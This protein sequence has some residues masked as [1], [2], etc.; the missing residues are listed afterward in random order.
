[1][2]EKNRWTDAQASAGAP[3]AGLGEMSGSIGSALLPN[4]FD[5]RL[6]SRQAGVLVAGLLMNPQAESA[7]N[8]E[9]RVV[10][11]KG[12]TW[13]K[14]GDAWSLRDDFGKKIDKYDG[15]VVGVEKNENGVVVVQLKDGRTVHE[16]P[17]GSVFTYSKN[18]ELKRIDS[19]DGTFRE[20]DWDGKELVGFRSAKGAW[21]RIK[22]GNEYKDKWQQ[23]NVVN[24]QSWDGKIQVDLTNGEVSIGPADGAKGDTTVYKTDGKQVTVHADGSKEIVYPN[25]ESFKYDA[26]GN[27]TEGNYID[28]TKRIFGW[29]KNPNATGDNDRF[30]LTSLT[31]N[32]KEGGSYHH[33]LGSDGK[34]TVST[35]ENNV[36]GKAVPEDLIINVD[37]KEGVYS[38][39]DTK[40][41]I[42]TRRIPGGIEEDLDKN[43]ALLETRTRLLNGRDVIEYA[44]TKTRVEKLNGQI[45]AVS[46]EGQSVEAVRD[47]KNRIVELIDRANNRLYTKNDQGEFQV[48]ALDPDK[49]F[50]K[51]DDLVRQGEVKLHPDGTVVFR[52]K[53]GVTIRQKLGAAAESFEGRR[54]I[55]KLTEENALLSVEQK[56]RIKENIDAIE[57]RDELSAAEKAECYAQME[58]LLTDESGTFFSAEQRAELFEQVSWHIANPKRNEQGQHDTCQTTDLRII[59]IMENPSIFAK[60][61]A[62]LAIK[63]SFVTADGTT[64][65]PKASSLE[66]GNGEEAKFPPDPSTRT[67][68]GRIWDVACANAYWQRATVTP[69]GEYVLKGSISYEEGAP[70]DRKD[71]GARLCKYY[72]RGGTRW[73]QELTNNKGEVIK[74]PCLTGTQMM[75]AYEQVTGI[76]QNGR[77]IAHPAVGQLSGSAIKLVQSHDDLHRGLSRGKIIQIHT[78]HPWITEDAVYGSATGA[79]DYTGGWHV[80]VA[81][82]YAVKPKT[83]SVD[84]S[85]RPEV[86]HP[87]KPQVILSEMYASMAGEYPK[88]A[89][90]GTSGGTQ[91]SSTEPRARGD[92]SNETKEPKAQ[93]EEEAQSGEV[94]VKKYGQVEHLKLPSGWNLLPPERPEWAV[95]GNS[96]QFSFTGD[97]N[98]S[99]VLYDRGVRS[100]N[101]A[102]RKFRDLLAKPPHKLDSKEIQE[103]KVTLGNMADPNFFELREIRTENL[104]GKN[105]LVIDGEWK[106]SQTQFHGLMIDADGSG[107][108][109]QEIFFEATPQSYAER[110][111]EV[112]D[113]LR[114]LKWKTGK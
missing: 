2:T 17:D 97:P 27:I 50:K 28:G 13:Q 15:A 18:K 14:D 29:Q 113:A 95:I 112:T 101:E 88:P 83:V 75:D 64:I 60:L 19:A 107:S 99:V 12:L 65:T 33:Q 71:K 81:A 25:K 92:G 44:R 73:R 34:W 67:W 90:K 102:G 47:N 30:Q 4:F 37:S 89:A 41:G 7:A 55:D 26:D 93:P 46:R 105:V 40:T 82:D 100:S 108:L 39:T 78:S 54:Y 86:D 76:K 94:V 52:T 66:R 84:N 11:Q 1:M 74:F 53:D 36:W 32:R 57:K 109:V 59:A 3:G 79:S 111:K 43:N 10:G 104:N 87:P 22:V 91:Q 58:R 70:T 61:I 56:K 69:G 103:I 51:P 62:D 24:A 6:F 23:K 8:A 49:P 16:N 21:S 110:I 98:C 35:Y 38:S 45:V 85:W 68:A 5:V 63:G 20:F 9:N 48:T 80:V 42:T 106:N 72:D 31:V 96:R 77:F 114:K